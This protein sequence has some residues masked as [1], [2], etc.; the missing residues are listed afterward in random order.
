MSRHFKLSEFQCH[1]TGENHIKPEFIGKLDDLRE[2]CGFPFVITSGYRSPRH[3]KE[4]DKPGG[5][6]QHSAGIAA[7]IAVGDG[8]QRWMIVQHA[9]DL[10]FTGIGAAKTFIHVDLREG[11][12]V[13]W[14]Y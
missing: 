12:Q 7:D 11:Q 13:L 2:V 14:T 4:V 8:V 5:P 6:G 10:G 9:M 1:E 3:S